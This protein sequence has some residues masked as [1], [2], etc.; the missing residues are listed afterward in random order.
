[1]AKG[2]SEVFGEHYDKTFAPVSQLTSVRTVMS[3]GLQ[4]ELEVVQGDFKTAFLNSPMDREDMFIEL[5]EGITSNGCK[6]ARLLKGLYG[7]KQAAYLWWD[8]LSGFM[9]VTF[10]ELQ[11]SKTE[12]CLWYEWTAT[13]KTL[14]LLYVDDFILL[15]NDVEWKNSF[16]TKIQNRYKLSKIEDKVSQMLG[17]SIDYNVQKGYCTFSQTRDIDDLVEIYM[18]LVKDQTPTNLPIDVDFDTSAVEADN[19]SPDVP[20][21]SIMGSLTWISRNTRPDIAPAVSLL[22]RY[23]ANFKLYHWHQALK[24]VRYLNHTRSQKL[25][26]QKLS[27]EEFQ[28]SIHDYASALSPGQKDKIATTVNEINSNYIDKFILMEQFA[29]SDWATDKTTRKSQTGHCLYAYGNMISWVSSRQ[30]IVSLSSTEAEYIA[31]TSAIKDGI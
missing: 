31:M 21:R 18:P 5:P 9:K 16:L 29:D 8:N 22:S 17:V 23:N 15:T 25:Y 26:Y 7:L 27:S 19:V 6:F 2:F 24:V 28:E 3:M 10:P 13:R 14:L 4:H 30:Q 1:V 20:Y 12:P 11:Q